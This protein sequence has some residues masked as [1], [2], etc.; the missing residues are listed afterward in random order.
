M[1][2]LVRGA[3][4]WAAEDHETVV[5]RGSA[6]TMRGRVHS[7]QGDNRHAAS[8][9]TLGTQSH[10]VEWCDQILIASGTMICVLCAQQRGQVK[11]ATASGKYSARGWQPWWKS[12]GINDGNGDWLGYGE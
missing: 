4:G 7:L 2:L 5:M 8:P 12:G 10:M 11:V 3:E 6:Q 9:S 1:Y